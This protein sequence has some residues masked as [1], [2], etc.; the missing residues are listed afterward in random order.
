MDCGPKVLAEVVEQLR[1][2]KGPYYKRWKE[3]LKLGMLKALE[4]MP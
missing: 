2:R 4:E 3:G 1:Q